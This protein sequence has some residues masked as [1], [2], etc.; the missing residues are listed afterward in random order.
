[1]LCNMSAYNIDPFQTVNSLQ[2][3]PLMSPVQW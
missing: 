1:M 3:F 2:T